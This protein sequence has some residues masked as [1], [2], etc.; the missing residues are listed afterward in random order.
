MDICHKV[1]KFNCLFKVF[2]LTF[3]CG[4]ILPAQAQSEKMSPAWSFTTF[5]YAN[6][7]NISVHRQIYIA[8]THGAFAVY[9]AYSIKPKYDIRFGLK[10]NTL[11]YSR[12]ATDSFEVFT[13]RIREYY[14][15]VPMSLFYYPSRTERT[16]GLY[17]GL[18]PSVLLN[19]FVSKQEDNP[20]YYAIARDPS[21]P[22]RFDMGINF[23]ASLKLSPRWLISADYTYS[24]T[25]KAQEAYNSGRFSQYSIGLGFQIN[26]PNPKESEIELSKKEEIIHFQKKNMV[27]LVR[28]KTE[29]KKI[30][31]YRDRGYTQDAD[32]LL[33]EVQSENQTTIDAFEQGFAFCEV[34]YFYD[35]VSRLV[36]DE[37]YE[38][39]ILNR[40][41]TLSD[42]VIGDSTDIIIGEFGSP[43]S[44]AFGSSSGFGLVIYDYQF[45]QM[46]EPFPYYIST[47]YG[48]VSR[49]EAV[50]KFDKKLREYQKLR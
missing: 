22:G 36:S 28:L 31:Y 14:L 40:D 35:T 45:N 5:A 19:K 29:A 47:Y 33:E 6:L 18:T 26:P 24:F 1:Q 41:G 3:C 7:T 43:Y 44:E 27:M 2:I 46:K 13:Q 50:I 8:N 12:N 48:L 15:D 23:G 37:K 25:N 21:K 16:W 9:G 20:K 49:K 4:L 39:N 17:A 42:L 32:E 34:R 38:G 30:K 11:A 10:V